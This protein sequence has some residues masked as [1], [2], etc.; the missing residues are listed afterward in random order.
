MFCRHCFERLPPGSE[1]YA[2]PSPWGGLALK[3]LHLP[4]LKSDVHSTCWFFK[5]LCPQKIRTSHSSSV[6]GGIGGREWGWDGWVGGY[7]ARAIRLCFSVFL[8]LSLPHHLTIFSFS[9]GFFLFFL[10]HLLYR[11]QT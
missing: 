9:K 2:L 6:L 5:Q 7:G 8:F 10:Y 1:F 11:A 3:G 4:N